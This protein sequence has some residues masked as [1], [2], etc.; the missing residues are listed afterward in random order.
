VDNQATIVIMTKGSLREET[1]HIGLRKGFLRENY[2]NQ[3]VYPVDC[4]TKNQL[5]DIFTKSLPRQSFTRLRDIIMGQE[6]IN[7]A[8]YYVQKY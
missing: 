3:Q 7:D 8:N 2:H 1:K 6:R 5:A 4:S